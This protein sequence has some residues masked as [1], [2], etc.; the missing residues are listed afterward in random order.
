V[1]PFDD[2]GK[3]RNNMTSLNGAVVVVTGA[4]GGIGTNFVHEA[5][6][7]GASKVYATA[8]NPRR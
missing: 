7:R 8:R 4:N 2:N 5:L 3:N 1:R 6:A